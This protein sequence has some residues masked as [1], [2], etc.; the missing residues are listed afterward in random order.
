M[1]I[2]RSAKKAIRVSARKR[3]FNMRRAQ[4]VRRSS[5]AL[6]KAAAAHDGTKAQALL[7]EAYAAVD[8]AVKRGVLTPQTAARRKAR[9]A[10]IV[11]AAGNA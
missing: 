7:R 10:K 1:A 8:K 6:E 5:K 3:I 4:E 2:T 11:R 9:L